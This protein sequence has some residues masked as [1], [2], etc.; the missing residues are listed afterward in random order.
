MV[1]KKALATALL[2][3]SAAHGV[4]K[5]IREAGADDAF[6][7]AVTGNPDIDKEIFGTDIGFRELFLPMPKPFGVDMT[8]M[9]AI[10]RGGV[11]GLMAAWNAGL[12]NSTTVPDS[13]KQNNAPLTSR[14]GGLPTV[15]GSLVF[16][17]KNSSLA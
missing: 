10:H 8:R 4:S 9:G 5:G 3:G 1:G 2:V 16:A 17:L 13:F 15:D 11:A 7:E 14:R 12:V 6:Y